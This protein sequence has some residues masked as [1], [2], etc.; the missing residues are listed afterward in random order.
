MPR[1]TYLN[2]EV[3]KEIAGRLKFGASNLED[4]LKDYAKPE[5]KPW[6]FPTHPLDKV[7]AEFGLR[8]FEY[9][10]LQEAALREMPKH[11]TLQVLYKKFLLAAKLVLD[12]ELEKARQFERRQSEEKNK[13]DSSYRRKM[14]EWENRNKQLTNG[15]TNVRETIRTRWGRLGRSIAVMLEKD[16]R[17]G[18]MAPRDIYFLDLL[19]GRGIVETDLNPD[20]SKRRVLKVD[21]DAYASMSIE[22]INEVIHDLNNSPAGDFITKPTVTKL[23]EA[24]A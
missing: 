14:T 13:R 20:I 21:W 17:M 4:R 9:K 12:G 23:D 11:E 10:V 16:A 3:L 5:P 8:G 6:T 19:G 22:D 7:A 2:D 1:D 15:W 18:T 24:L